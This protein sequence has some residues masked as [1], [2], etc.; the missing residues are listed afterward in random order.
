MISFYCNIF[1]NISEN[2]HPPL[3]TYR[4]LASSFCQKG[5]ILTEL[6]L[7]TPSVPWE[8]IWKMPLPTATFRGSSSVRLWPWLRAFSCW[9]KRIS[10][11]RT[12]RTNVGMCFH[13]CHHRQH[14]LSALLCVQC[15]ARD[16]T[17]STSFD[18]PGISRRSGIT[19]STIEG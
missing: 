14:F 9:G 11:F 12:Y 8:Y 19:H 15:A 13:F 6:L 17:H 7:K 2:C 10:F 4:L 5:A 3:Y 16:F 18:H 1:S